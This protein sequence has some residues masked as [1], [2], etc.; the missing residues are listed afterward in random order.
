MNII[1]AHIH[2][3]PGEGHFSA[4]ARAAGHENTPE[5]VAE[6]FSRLGVRHALV[7]GNRGLD[8]ALHAYPDNMSYLIGLD[9][10]VL[11]PQA[12]EESIRLV[13]EHLGR[14]SCAGIKVYAGYCRYDLAD[15]VYRPFFEL[16]GTYQ[17]P[18][19]VHTGVTASSNALLKY[20]HPL[21]LDEVAV[22][23][24][25]VRFVMCHFGNPWLPDAAAV[26]EKNGNVV[27]DLSGLLVGRVD[28]PR[29]AAEQA[30]YLQQLKTWIAYVEDYEKFLY[31]TDWPLVN[32][33]DYLEY[34][35][36]LIP[37]RHL[38]KVLFSNANRIYKLGLTP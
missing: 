30:G 7:M 9:Q 18:V 37:D 14:K 31:G 35:Q 27:A 32:M 19:A 23:H 36:R 10:N 1:D 16:A 15:P 26:L 17:K 34:M 5:H 12:R 21:Q 11:S 38:E 3:R 29:Y 25:R 33:G 13:E 4:I 22:T 6:A 20:S 2:F 24:P 8:I 28:F